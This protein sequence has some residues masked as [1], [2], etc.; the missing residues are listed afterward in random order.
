[1]TK[2]QIIQVAT[3]VVIPLLVAGLKWL[4]PRVPNK[5]LPV[6]CPIL[7]A[8]IDVIA[9]G[10]IGTGT[11]WGAALGSA[12][13]G[14]REAFD[15]LSGNAAKP[16]RTEPPAPPV[17][18][19]TGALQL[20]ALAL[21][22]MFLFGCAW[23]SVT[24]KSPLLTTNNFVATDAD[25]YPSFRESKVTGYSLF[26]G[27]EAAKVKLANRIWNGDGQTINS[28]QTSQSDMGTQMKELGIQALKSAENAYLLGQ[29]KGGTTPTPIVQIVTN[30][31]A[32]PP[33]VDTNS[34]TWPVTVKVAD[35]KATVCYPNG[36]CVVVPV[37]AK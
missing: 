19:I 30:T 33:F 20:L 35:G 22:P 32:P 24:T 23:T 6:L 4:W 18:N 5:L 16:S 34:A 2:Q 3:P 12:G 27:T 9:N 21:V 14:L 1:M 13:V 29:G 26:Q 37:T 15:Q 10:T 25:G 31:V 8:L 17:G 36:A 7:G 11:V 28:D